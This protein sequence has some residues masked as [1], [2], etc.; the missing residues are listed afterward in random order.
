VC[1]CVSVRGET[2]WWCSFLK[3]GFPPLFLLL[4]LL[5]VF[6]F[7]FFLGGGI[8]GIIPVLF[9]SYL[10]LLSCEEGR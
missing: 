10:P 5:G 8:I 1:E 4:L 2:R 3:K 9:F 6:F 7:V